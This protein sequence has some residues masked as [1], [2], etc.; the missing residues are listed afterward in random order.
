MLESLNIGQIFYSRTSTDYNVIVVK[1][2]RKMKPEYHY[3]PTIL[4]TYNVISNF[5]Q[6][7]YQLNMFDFLKIYTTTQ[8]SRDE[9]IDKII[10]L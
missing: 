1:I 3:P 8:I 10:E 6:P 4:I 7:S 5:I 9:I 2:E